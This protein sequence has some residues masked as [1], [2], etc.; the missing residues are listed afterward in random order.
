MYSVDK[1]GELSI[2]EFLYR[3]IKED[4]LT[5]KIGAGEKLPSK[6]EMA[7][8]CGVSLTSVQN[9]YENLQSEG[10]IRSEYRRGY[11]AEDR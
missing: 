7:S 10:Y 6:R 3:L 4:I 9:A 11:F 2:T 8:L 5:G 1:R